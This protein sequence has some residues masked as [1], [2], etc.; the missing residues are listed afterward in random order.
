MTISETQESSAA[1]VG[2][3]V[4]RRIATALI[5]LN[6]ALL[7]IALSANLQPSFLHGQI[8]GWTGIWQVGTGQDYILLPLELT[9][10]TR[11]DEPL[12]VEV[13]YDNSADWQSIDL[14]QVVRSEAGSQLQRTRW[15]HL[16][17]L[18]GWIAEQQPESEVLAVLT[19]QLV[20]FAEHQRNTTDATSRQI[21]SI[22]L[23]HPYVM[24]YDE[25]LAS[26]GIQQAGDS[27]DDRVVYQAVVIREANGLVRVVPQQDPALTSKPGRTSPRPSSV[28]EGG[29][30]E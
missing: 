19:V 5:F 30:D 15:A 14:P 21:H 20:H 24:S 27:I 17:R 23:L 2:S 16:G 26:G 18:V 8:L 29:D 28:L 10:A 13:Q 3:P 11:L 6:F 22:R 4:Q 25:D 9:H 1:A 7:V 12:V